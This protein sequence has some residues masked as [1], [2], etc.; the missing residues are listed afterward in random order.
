[1]HNNNLVLGENHYHIKEEE[2][3]LMGIALFFQFSFVW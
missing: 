1:M 2:I 3:L